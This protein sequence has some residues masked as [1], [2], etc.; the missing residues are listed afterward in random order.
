MKQIND[1]F[2]FIFI[3]LCVGIGFHL[4]EKIVALVF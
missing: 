2:G 4:A 1:G 3:G